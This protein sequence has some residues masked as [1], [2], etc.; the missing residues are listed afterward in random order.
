MPG[1]RGTLGP[2]LRTHSIC[3]IP[4]H[5]LGPLNGL[6]GLAALMLGVEALTG[7]LLSLF[8]VPRFG[9]ENLAYRSIVAITSEV[10]YGLLLRSVH[11]H[12]GNLMLLLSVAHFLK[13]Y[14]LGNY[15]QPKG[16]SHLL[17]VATGLTAVAAAVT[18]YSMRADYVGVEAILI[19]QNLV[20]ALPMGGLIFR[21]IYGTGGMDD[22]LLRYNA[23]HFT[24][25]GLLFLELL[26]HVWFSHRHHAA[27]PADGSRPRPLMPVWPNFF[28]SVSSGALM[29]VG[30]LLVLSSL[31]PPGL[32]EPYVPGTAI[33]PGVPEW[34][35]VADYTL[36]KSGIHPGF[37]GVFVPLAAVA[38]IALMPWIEGTGDRDR[39]IGK[40]RFAAAYLAA[41]MSVFAVFT[42]WGYLTVGEQVSLEA[43]L[44]V[45]AAAAAV[46]AAAVLWL[47]RVPRVRWPAR[48]GT[49]PG[50]RAPRDRLA[51]LGSGILSSA[52]KICWTA[53]AGQV[54]IAYLGWSL[55]QRG[56]WLWA[57]ASLGA[58]LMLAG[59]TVLVAKAATLDSPV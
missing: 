3:K 10:R 41:F 20:K 7:I 58:S 45:G 24:L 9:G 40:R 11:Y 4:A 47:T 44:A 29:A 1:R 23:L 27:P 43:E 50:D 46:P 18:G 8:Y 37:A 15:A 25:G 14:I 6:G 59:L 22:S 21:A 54:A 5:S 39:R 34:F 51:A 17:G 42:V 16:L 30:A 32:A 48:P 53:L 33:P 13:T 28:L 19:G 57:G 49:A 55:S 35:M 56:E 31:F 52:G 38:P 12:A 36:I 26:L 2:W